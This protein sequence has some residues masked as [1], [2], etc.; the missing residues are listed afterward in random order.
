MH[1]QCACLEG[2]HRLTMATVVPVGGLGR[3]RAPGDNFTSSK[4]S[5]SVLEWR[6]ESKH[7]NRL[8]SKILDRLL[9]DFLQFLKVHH[10]L[11]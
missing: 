4:T 8:H 5:S 11:R 10:L 6:G 1:E 3:R 9:F 7:R 2:E